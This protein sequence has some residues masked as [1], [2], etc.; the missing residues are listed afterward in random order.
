MSQSLA[1]IKQIGSTLQG[2]G[3]P[4]D[5]YA[6]SFAS[7]LL[8]NPDSTTLVDNSISP[9]QLNFPGLGSSYPFANSNGAIFRSY[10]GLG[11]YLIDDYDNF[12][13]SINGGG[14]YDANS[15]LGPGVLYSASGGAVIWT[16]FDASV[17]G[18]ASQI[19]NG[20]GGLVALGTDNSIELLGSTDSGNNS[21]AI[22]LASVASNGGIAIGW[23]AVVSGEG[24]SIGYPGSGITSATG[25]VAVGNNAV[26]TANG[27]AIGRTVTASGFGANF[28]S[29]TYAGTGLAIGGDEIAVPNGE[30]YA[31]HSLYD[32]STV[33]INT[34]TPV[35]WCSV[36][37]NG[38]QSW[39]PYYQ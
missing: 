33:P 16:P 22:G 21:I 36:L 28:V 2:W 7:N 34:V 19:V 38:T 23:A 26:E 6:A 27:V 1:Q 24:V 35:A 17:I 29:G 13:L 9:E 4:L 18:A 11:Q 12:Y 31:T 37:V 5:S 14:I 30:G 10:G 39:L 20:A 3:A 32:A 15:S 25:G 8:L